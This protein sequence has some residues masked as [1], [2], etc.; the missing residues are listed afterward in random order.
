MDVNAIIDNLGYLTAEATKRLAAACLDNLTDDEAIEEIITVSERRVG[1]LRRA[2]LVPAVAAALIG[3]VGLSGGL[4]YLSLNHPNT[5][6]N[7]MSY[8]K[9][10]W[11]SVAGSAVPAQLPAARATE[12]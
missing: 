9:S 11:A 12:D 1:F 2:L 8:P 7:V 6:L 4:S 3:M 5:Y 10:A